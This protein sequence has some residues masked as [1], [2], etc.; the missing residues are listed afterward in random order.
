MMIRLRIAGVALAILILPVF[1]GA[2]KEIVS[3][4]NGWYLYQGNH[5]LSERWGLHTEY[6]WRR[7]DWIANWQQSLIRVGAEYYPDASNSVTVGYLFVETYPYGE[8]PVAAAFGEHR[9]W[10]QWSSN[11]RVGR[12]YVNH[13]YRLEQRFL[14]QPAEKKYRFRQRARYRLFLTIPLA[15]RDLTNHSFFIATS[16]EVFLGFGKGIGRNVL[17]QSRLHIGLGFRFNAQA[18]LQL[19]YLNQYIIKP[20]GLQ[21]ERNHT[22]QCGLFYNID[23]R[24]GK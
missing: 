7:S 18:N 14:E 10:E 5:R 15:Q 12:V 1:A 22:L 3:Q 17:D 2:Q 8:Q 24:E 9:I 4:Y 23:F 19:G 20:D 11:Q 13:R 21:H 16:A 6:Q